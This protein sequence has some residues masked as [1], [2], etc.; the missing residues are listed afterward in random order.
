MIQF[1]NVNR[2]ERNYRSNTKRAYGDDSQFCD[3]AN[4]ESDDS[5]KLNVL[6]KESFRK[7]SE[8][9]SQRSACDQTKNDNVATEKQ[10]LQQLL[11][12][13]ERLEASKQPKQFQWSD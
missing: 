13:V 8:S 10:L 11:Q 9:Q 7:K 1:R 12:R 3:I 5:A 2:G 6:N 4:D